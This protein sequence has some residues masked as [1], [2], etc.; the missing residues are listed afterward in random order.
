MR[1]IIFHSVRSYALWGGT[2]LAGV[3]FTITSGN[4]FYTK[5]AADVISH[6]TFTIRPIALSTSTRTGY[7]V[8]RYGLAP[9]SAPDADPGAR[10]PRIK[11]MK[12]SWFE[13]RRCLDVGCNEGDLTL[14]LVRTF[15]PRQMVGVDIDGYLV[16]RARKVSFDFFRGFCFSRMFIFDHLT[17]DVTERSID[18]I[19]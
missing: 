3:F 7:Y 15:R 5:H 9:G 16:Q 19:H 1:Q 13:G 11:L 18:S 17:R 2:P 4:S 12:R 10:D 8:T 6:P 14:A